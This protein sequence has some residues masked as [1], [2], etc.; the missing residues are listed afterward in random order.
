MTYGLKQ[1]GLDPRLK[2]I[3][4]R[5]GD[6]GLSPRS[7][8]CIDARGNE[9]LHGNFDRGTH[10][11]T[12]TEFMSRMLDRECT[13]VEAHFKEAVDKLASLNRQQTVSMIVY[14]DHGKHRSV[15][16]AQLLREAIA[17]EENLFHVEAL[18]HLHKHKWSLKKCGHRA[19]KQC[20]DTEHCSAAKTELY[21]RAHKIFSRLWQESN[22]PWRTL[23]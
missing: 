20:D 10:I 11:G 4:D 13:K 6:L 15:A 22:C 9:C 5:L 3:E 12:N 23:K 21:C 8:I 14:C 2:P 7:T 18:Q 1:D 16:L 19:C 17:R